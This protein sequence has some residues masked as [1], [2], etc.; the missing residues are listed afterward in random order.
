MDPQKVLQAPIDDIIFEGRNKA[1]GAYF[2]RKIYNKHLSRALLVAV[3]LIVLGTSA[4]LIANYI[5]GILKQEEDQE[6]SV[7]INLENLDLP[8]QEETP[9]PP[10]PVEPPPLKSTIR[11]VVPEPKKDEEVVDE[12]PPPPVEALQEADISTVTQEGN[13]EGVSEG[14]IDAP[15]AEEPAPPPIIEEPKKE[16][17]FKVVEQM[18]EFDGGVAGLLKYL[19]ENIKYPALARENGIE[20]KVIVQFI[21]DENGQVSQAKIVRGIGGGCDQEALRVVETMNG[22]WKP[23]KQRG[24]PVKVWFTLPVN[25]QLE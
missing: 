5:S 21:V 10:P 20:G 4:P 1:Y 2:L 12:E 3:I 18:P 14:V 19:A 25:F 7:E 23:G 15:P 11:Y 13:D 9:P 24:R 16:E 22:K 17:V 8:P 6:V